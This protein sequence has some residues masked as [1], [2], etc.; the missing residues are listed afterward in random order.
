MD[1]LP[2]A[3]LLL[4]QRFLKENPDALKSLGVSI[5]RGGRP[6]KSTKPEPEFLE[7]DEDTAQDLKLNFSDAKKL[8]KKAKPPISEEQRAIL[9]ERLAKAR[10]AKIKMKEEKEQAKAQEKAKRDK[11]LVAVKAGN[12]D[13]PRILIPIKPKIKRN[14]K[15]F[16]KQEEEEEISDIPTTEIETE[17]DEIIERKFKRK[18]EKLKEIDNKIDTVVTKAKPQGSLF[19]NALSNW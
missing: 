15:K 10:E 7:V 8:E 1:T 14:K 13:K 17:D 11:I 5:A 9:I 4:L 6:K 3:E 16:Q 18:V 19:A 2:S 12:E